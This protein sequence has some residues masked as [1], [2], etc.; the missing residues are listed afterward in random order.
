MFG[1]KQ[2]SFR[3]LWFKKFKWLHYDEEN[4]KAYCFVCIKT[5]ETND[6]GGESAR[7]STKSDS[8]V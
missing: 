6:M 7:S 5:I 3:P 1:N 4:D 8:L 2:R